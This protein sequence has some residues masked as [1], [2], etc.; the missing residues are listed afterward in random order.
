MRK[1]NDERGITFLLST[2]D[3]MVIDNTSRVIRMRD[4]RL[5]EEE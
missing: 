1:L 5:L 3:P 4:G 2:H